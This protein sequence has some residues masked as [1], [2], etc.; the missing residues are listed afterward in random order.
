[1][2]LPTSGQVEEPIY[3][4]MHANAMVCYRRGI[5]ENSDVTGGRD[6]RGRARA[7][8]SSELRQAAM[9]FTGFRGARDHGMHVTRRIGCP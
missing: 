4:G 2:S 6:E 1:M 7:H 9:D 8:V 3:S 5:Q